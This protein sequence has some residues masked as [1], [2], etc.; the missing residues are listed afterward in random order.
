MASHSPGKKA[1]G[2]YGL[3]ETVNLDSGQ[4]TC[5]ETIPE[6]QYVT[7]D[8]YRADLADFR[9]AMAQF[10]EEVRGSLNNIDVKLAELEV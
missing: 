4:M 2:L 3:Y 8:K 1:R 7:Y 6:E 5:S 9:G 10:R